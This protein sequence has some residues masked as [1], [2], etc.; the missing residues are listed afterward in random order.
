MY[1]SLAKAF[2]ERVWTVFGGAIVSPLKRSLNRTILSFTV[3]KLTL[4]RQEGNK[5]AIRESVYQ[6]FFFQPD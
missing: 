6:G 3:F 2:P 4:M 5:T 1:P